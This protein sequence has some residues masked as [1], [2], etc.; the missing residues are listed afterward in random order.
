MR[1]TQCEQMSSGLPPK[2]DSDASI[3]DVAKVPEGDIRRRSSGGTAMT[4]V[5]PI[6]QPR[7]RDRASAGLRWRRIE[8]YRIAPGW[9]W[10]EAIDQITLSGR[11][12]EGGR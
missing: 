11:S 10:L 9:G 8:R 2:A 7:L 3:S 6:W 12:C 4:G 5:S 1:R